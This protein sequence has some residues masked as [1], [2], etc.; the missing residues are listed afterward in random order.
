LLLHV[1]GIFVAPVIPVRLLRT[2]G[3]GPFLATNAKPFKDIVEKETPGHSEELGIVTRILDYKPGSDL[4]WRNRRT[5]RA[6]RR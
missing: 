2:L 5:D 4:L 6:L 3:S 1:R